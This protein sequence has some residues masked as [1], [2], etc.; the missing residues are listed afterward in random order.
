M[1]VDLSL[2]SDVTALKKYEPKV[3]KQS[4]SAM[5]VSSLLSVATTYSS[6]DDTGK[7]NRQMS[8]DEDVMIILEVNM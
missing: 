4:Y 3:A 2:A 7:N 5:S 6:C 1:R 8:S